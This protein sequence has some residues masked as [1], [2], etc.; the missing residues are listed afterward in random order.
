MIHTI[1]NLPIPW[2]ELSEENVIFDLDGTL[3]TGDLGETVFIHILLQDQIG[4]LLQWIRTIAA[5]AGHTASPEFVLRG[6]EAQAF[7]HYRNLLENGSY[8]EAYGFAAQWI[9]Q[10]EMD[11]K[12]IAHS[13]LRNNFNPV[14]IHIHV[15]TGQQSAPFPAAYGARIKPSM[16]VLSGRLLHS[17]AECWIVS[18]SPQR[19]CEAAA[20][21]LGFQQ[22]RV[23]GVHARDGKSIAP[24]GS[25]KVSALQRRS[26]QKPLLAFGDSSGDRELLLFARQGVLI[27]SSHTGDLLE[28]ARL[29]GWFILEDPE[30]G[31]LN[32]DTERR[33]R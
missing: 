27:G 25:G 28:E 23:L 3:L 32:Q 13:I 11:C 17:G 5:P 21:Q 6:Q 12:E 26:V 29:N 10:Q 15:D 9:G 19:V 20:E 16:K 22:D 7:K 8:G 31:D 33:V 2:I 14:Q 1:G 30:A 18:A 24:W 4:R